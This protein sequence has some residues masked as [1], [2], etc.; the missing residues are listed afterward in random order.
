M[1]PRLYIRSLLYYGQL[2]I[3]VN[4]ACTA[5]KAVSMHWVGGSHVLQSP[6]FVPE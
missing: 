4:V 6:D 3:N 1:L 5:L 2:Q